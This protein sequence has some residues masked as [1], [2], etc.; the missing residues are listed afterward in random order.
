[1]P[2][3]MQKDLTAAVVCAPPPLRNFI[4]FRLNTCQS[5]QLI[6][7]TCGSK[8]FEPDVMRAAT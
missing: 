3:G 2:R 6:V 4:S 8:R 7:T 5:W 1:M